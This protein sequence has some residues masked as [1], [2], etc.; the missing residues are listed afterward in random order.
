MLESRDEGPRSHLDASVPD[1]LVCQTLKLY[2]TRA[3][4]PLGRF[5]IH[6]DRFCFCGDRFWMLLNASGCFC[7]HADSQQDCDDH[8]RACN[9]SCFTIACILERHGPLTAAVKRKH[10]L[11]AAKVDQVLNTLWEILAAPVGCLTLFFVLILLETASLQPSKMF[12]FLVH[13]DKYPTEE[14]SSPFLWKDVNIMYMGCHLKSKESN[15]A[16][17]RMLARW[18]LCVLAC[19]P[20]AAP[21]TALFGTSLCLPVG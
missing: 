17:S 19:S 1:V 16:Q 4:Q 20:L 3:A 10:I 9:D 5:C 12:H 2:S 8:F 14:R 7:S 18:F 21:I 11:T 13:D 15:G 6:D